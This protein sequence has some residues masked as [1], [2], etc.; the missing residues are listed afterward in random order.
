MSMK[1]SNDTKW[2]RTIDL[3]ILAQHLNHCATA[4]PSKLRKKHGKTSVRV[5]EDCQ[6][7]RRKQ[8]MFG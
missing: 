8:N 1:N 7:A 6:L 4:V 3:P 2:D 5:D